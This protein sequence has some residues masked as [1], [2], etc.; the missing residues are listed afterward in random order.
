[1]YLL[2]DK[3]NSDK[4]RN[5]RIFCDD[6]EFTYLLRSS[7]K[8]RF[9]IEVCNYTDSMLSYLFLDKKVYERKF[10]VKFNLFIMSFYF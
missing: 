3:K 10:Y 1:M 6:E 8:L 9:R 7:Q 2:L 4:T 5:C